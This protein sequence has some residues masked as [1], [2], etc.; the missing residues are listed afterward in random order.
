MMAKN[1][2]I[3]VLIA[4]LIVIPL[5][6]FIARP[7]SN[8]ETVHILNNIGEEI[9]IKLTADNTERVILEK[10]IPPF[11]GVFTQR[12]NF[13]GGASYNVTIYNKN[14]TKIMEGRNYGY[15]TQPDVQSSFFYVDKAGIKYA[16]WSPE[17]PFIFLFGIFVNR[18]S[19]LI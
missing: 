19:C 12:V 18:L 13:A 14:G 10:N 9:T 2:K 11:S 16:A 8:G 5:F 1:K 15:V 4:A 7:C 17:N 6:F 3:W